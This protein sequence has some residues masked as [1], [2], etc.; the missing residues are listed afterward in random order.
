M[1]S[2]VKI[3]FYVDKN[4]GVCLIFG[5]NGEIWHMNMSNMFL[6]K[7]QRRK[8]AKLIRY[9]ATQR[10]NY[11]TKL[12]EDFF[13]GE[14]TRSGGSYYTKLHEDFF[15]GRSSTKGGDL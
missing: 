1:V 9:V 13:M 6:A 5:E 8:D 2:I 15:M 4:V 12:H 11:Y 10:G 14:G 7:T 3:C